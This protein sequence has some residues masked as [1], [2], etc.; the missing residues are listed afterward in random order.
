MKFIFNKKL[1]AAVLLI[2]F[3]ALSINF[4]CADG[5]VPESGKATGDYT[6][7]DFVRVFVSYYNR[8]FGIIGSLALL[9]FIYGGVMFLIS[10][11]NSEK[12]EQAKKIITGAVIGL[13]IVFASYAIISFIMVQSEFDAAGTKWQTSGFDWWTKK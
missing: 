4:C 9:M 11:G 5:I 6:L 2:G 3:F 12:V 1:L 13:V 8:I 7:D 10:A